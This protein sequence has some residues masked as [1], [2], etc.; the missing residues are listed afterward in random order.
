MLALQVVLLIELTFVD[1]TPG[2]GSPGHAITG[3]R[4]DIQ[5]QHVS[6]SE[7]PI[8]NSLLWRFFIYNYLVSVIQMLLGLVREDAL[9]RLDLE[10]SAHGLDVFRHHLI[11]VL[12][13]D[14]L[15]SCLES[16]PCCHEHVGLLALSLSSE[17]KA[18]TAGCWISVDVCSQL[19]LDKVLHF[20][21][22]GV[23]LEWREMSAK[24]INGYAAWES[25][26]SFEFF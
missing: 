25:N 13:F 5:M 18:V 6:W 11:S 8:L 12:W 9:E 21:L 4:V 24:F 19:N 22:V 14:S 26:A 3:S 1:C 2:L 20:K 15:A 7:F 10:I 16:I 17:D 23:L